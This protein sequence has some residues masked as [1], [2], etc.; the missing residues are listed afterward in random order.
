L[1]ADFVRQHPPLGSKRAE[2]M[3]WMY[4]MSSTYRAQ[5]NWTRWPSGCTLPGQ[6]RPPDRGLRATAPR[7]VPRTSPMQE[8]Q[9]ERCSDLDVQARPK[10]GGRLRLIAT[11]V[12]PK[13]IRPYC[14]CRACARRGP[15]APHPPTV[16]G[17][18]RARCPRLIRSPRSSPAARSRVPAATAPLYLLPPLVPAHRSRLWPAPAPTSRL[19]A[20]STVLYQAEAGARGNQASRPGVARAV[21]GRRGSANRLYVAKRFKRQTEGRGTRLLPHVGGENWLYRLSCG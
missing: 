9:Y 10:C 19:T 11:I 20:D 13:T 1:V 6:E 2:S 17:G 14:S 4:P 16:R 8:V 12:H 3:R 15:I 21:R 18:R 7:A 5:H